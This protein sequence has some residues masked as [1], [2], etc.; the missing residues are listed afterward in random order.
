METTEHRA[1]MKFAPSATIKIK[2]LFRRALIIKHN[3]AKVLRPF[4]YLNIQ[5]LL[6]L[7][8]LTETIQDLTG[9][10]VSQGT[11]IHA[12]KELYKK[13][14]HPEKQIKQQLLASHV[15]HLDESGVRVNGKLNWIHTAC[16]PEL[17]Y[18]LF[19]LNAGK[20]PWMKEAFCRTIQGRRC[21]MGCHR[22]APISAAMLCAISTTTAS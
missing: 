12:N 7:K 14:A 2:L 3:M 17:T 18:Y 22:I 9:H 21:M 13:L 16:T 8:R 10:S 1:Q 11:I 5:Q 20:S 6:P 4:S 15:V 19:I